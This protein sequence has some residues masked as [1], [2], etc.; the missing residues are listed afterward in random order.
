[1]NVLLVDADSYDV[2]L[3]A[4]VLRRAGHTVRTAPDGD[5]ALRSL[6]A[7]RPDMVLLDVVLPRGDG[8]EL[9]RRIRRQA[10]TPVI[11]LTERAAEA[12]IVRGFES[13]ADDYMIKPVSA[14]QLLARMQAVLRRYHP[15]S[16]QFESKELCVGPL[17]VDTET[18][19]VIK[20]GCP[21][22]PVTRLEFSLLY[23][24]ALNAGQVV[25]YSRLIELAWGYSDE[26]SATLLKTH[27]SHLRR[28][29]DLP[30]FGPCSISAVA[31]SGYRLAKA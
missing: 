15:D 20:A 4:C 12:D 5:R 9:C 24:L 23:H 31:G 13:G 11:V 17:V 29:L 19:R 2:D 18:H 7:N 21:R 6:E 16:S 30:R 22:T 10:L 8:F 1:M 25:P 27:I 26:N 28:K 3:L 14:N